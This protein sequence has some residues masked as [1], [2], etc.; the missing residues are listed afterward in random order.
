M[1]VCVFVC[2]CVCVCVPGIYHVMG[3]KCPHKYSNTSKFWPCGEIVFG[4]HKETS[5]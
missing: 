1:C 4:P 2:A 5:L 3:T